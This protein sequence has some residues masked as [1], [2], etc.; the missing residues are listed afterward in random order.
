MTYSRGS[1]TGAYHCRPTL[2]DLVWLSKETIDKGERMGWNGNEKDIGAKRAKRAMTVLPI[3]NEP[4]LNFRAQLSW[5]GRFNPRRSIMHGTRKWD[6]H[7]VHCLMAGLT[8]TMAQPNVHAS[9]LGLTM[10]IV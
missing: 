9:P 3:E 5:R 6:R 7:T 8:W 4:R 2:R 1:A 10:S